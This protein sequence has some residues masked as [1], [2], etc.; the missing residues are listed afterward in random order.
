MFNPPMANIRRDR[1]G[2]CKTLDK[3]VCVGV[4]ILKKLLR[5][6]HSGGS[7][8]KIAGFGIVG[9]GRRPISQRD[10]LQSWIPGTISQCHKHP[11]VEQLA[12]GG[13]ELN[14]DETD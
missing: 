5:G 6:C 12:V 1:H 11:C 14:V 10:P 13:D 7:D 3:C 8:D 4:D 9:A 2:L